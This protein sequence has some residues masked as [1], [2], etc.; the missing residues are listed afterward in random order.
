MSS[1]VTGAKLESAPLEWWPLLGV[2]G[3]SL[4]VCLYALVISIC[5]YRT[6]KNALTD[7]LVEDELETPEGAEARLNPFDRLHADALYREVKMSKGL[8][9]DSSESSSDESSSEESSSEEEESSSSSSEESSSLSSASPVKK[10]KKKKKKKKDKKK[11]KKETTVVEIIPPSFVVQE[12]TSVVVATSS[13]PRSSLVS[14]AAPVV[15][16]TDVVYFSPSSQR[17]LHPEDL[18]P[19]DPFPHVYHLPPPPGMG[20]NVANMPPLPDGQGRNPFANSTARY[21]PAARGVPP[22]VSGGDFNRST[23]SDGAAGAGGGGGV[24]RDAVSGKVRADGGN[25]V[26]KPL[27][28]NDVAA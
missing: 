23:R 20:P 12:P 5:L 16:V 1:A 9:D 25:T 24:K 6:N 27:P 7:E 13:L 28:A 8:E 4:L 2:V 19:N 18:R 15:E 21:H 17:A 14:A 10:D 26:Y 11:K 3:G 22:G